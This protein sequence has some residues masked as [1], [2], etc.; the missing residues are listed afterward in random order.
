MAQAPARARAEYHRSHLRYYRK[1]NGPL[2]TLGLRGV[3]AAS[4]LARLVSSLRTDEAARARREEAR[5]ALA[6]ALR[7][8]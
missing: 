4:A 5:T 3:I 8:V 2:A 7:G 6:I 1:H